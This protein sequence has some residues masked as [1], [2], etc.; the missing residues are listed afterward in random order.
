MTTAL[1]ILE[2]ARKISA[3][4]VER[5]ALGEALLRLSNGVRGWDLYDLH[6]SR[7]SDRLDRL[8]RWDGNYRD[9]LI[10]IAEQGFGDAI[11]FMRFISQLEGRAGRVVVAMHDE[12]MDVVGGSHLLQ[13][14]ELVSKSAAWATGW[15][16]AAQ[17]ERLMSLPSRL[18]QPSVKAIGAYL[19]RPTIRQSLRLRAVAPGWLTLGVA[20]RSTPR[21]GFASRSW[22][23]RLTRVL[24][25]VGGV[26]LVALH[27]PRDISMA[28]HGAKVLDIRNFA[29]TVAVMAQCD[30]I[31]TADTVTAHLGPA[32]GIP[33]F[34]C[35]R[36]RPDWRWGT[37]A[38]PT[39]WYAHAE[40]V[41][42]GPDMRWE[43]VL[44]EV[45]RRI[46]GTR[47]SDQQ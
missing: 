22:P 34:I 29:D 21:R 2:E 3:P 38:R 11:Q 25:E 47:G 10:V 46:S 15:P 37:A 1:D 6:P 27:R 18:P 24:A 8:S 13:G 43:P 42:Q 26:R 17:W 12:L 44:A 5:Y 33:T 31:V 7:P 4:E 28:T 9:L 39:R 32:L 19:P 35:L 30:Y 45:S 20:W 23:A 36:Y 16:S 41:F 40:L 14:V